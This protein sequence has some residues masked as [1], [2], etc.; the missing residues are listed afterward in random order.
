MLAGALGGI[1]GGL[2]FGAMMATMGMLPMLAGMVGST[3]PWVGFG[4][5]MMISVFF[6]VVFT[7]VASRWLRTWGTGLL[8]SMLYGI[9]LWV[10]GPLVVMPMMMGG[11]LFAFTAGSMMSLM[12][13]VIYALVLSAVAVPMLRRRS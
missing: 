12:G 4:I 2:V 1:A 3:S 5:H 11:P 6:G 7:A 13:H 9:V 8:V 10:V